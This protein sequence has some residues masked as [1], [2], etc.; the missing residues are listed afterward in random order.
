MRRVQC[1]AIIAQNVP[2]S[3]GIIII[4]LI[5]APTDS[6]PT[7]TTLVFNATQIL[8]LVLY[9]HLGTISKPL[10]KTIKCMLMLSLTDQLV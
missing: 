3:S 9:N 4:V 7:A 8:S 2:I 1:Q 5:L 10:Q 6:T